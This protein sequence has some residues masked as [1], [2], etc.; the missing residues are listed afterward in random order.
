MILFFM[1]CPHLHQC[2]LPTDL[3]FHDKTARQ[4]RWI[5]N[6]CGLKDTETFHQN[7]THAWHS[8]WKTRVRWV[9]VLNHVISL[10]YIVVVDCFRWNPEQPELKRIKNQPAI[11]WSLILRPEH[12]EHASSPRAHDNATTETAFAHVWKQT[13]HHQRITSIQK[14]NWG[15]NAENWRSIEKM[16]VALV[17]EI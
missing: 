16:Q 12:P 13:R 4:S 14:S 6:R 10:N 5:R 17:Y 9:S 2:G 8:A 11:A 7:R 1:L 3:E 15:W